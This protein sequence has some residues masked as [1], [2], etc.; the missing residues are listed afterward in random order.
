MTWQASLCFKIYEDEAVTDDDAHPL[1]A[2]SAGGGGLVK[3]GSAS[4][5][6]QRMPS[7]PCLCGHAALSCVNESDCQGLQADETG[8]IGSGRGVMFAAMNL[9]QHQRVSVERCE[10]VEFKGVDDR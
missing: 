1:T 5:D 8:M 7:S 10:E 3:S 9:D 2:G 4:E 6:R